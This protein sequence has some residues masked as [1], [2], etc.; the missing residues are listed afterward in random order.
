MD[1]LQKLAKSIFE[2]CK[3]CGEPV[4]ESEA[5]GMAKMEL[6]AKAINSY[7]ETEKTKVKRK[8]TVKLDDRKVALISTLA[9]IL[10]D[11]FYPGL[12]NVVII[13]PQKEIGFKIGEDEY[14]FSLTKHKKAKK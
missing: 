5:L 7:T 14:S 6:G 9:E 8:R 4:T 12:A 13:N 10:E 11:R 2:E 3:K 1:K